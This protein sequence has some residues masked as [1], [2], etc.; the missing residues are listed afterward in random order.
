MSLPA[1]IPNS[2]ILLASGEGWIVWLLIIGGM[3]IFNLVKEDSAKRKYKEELDNIS[4]F[5]IKATKTTLP[6]N[7]NLGSLPCFQIEFK[8]WANHPTD[9]EIKFDLLIKD[10]S[11]DENGEEKLTFFVSPDSSLT[12]GTSRVFRF[13]RIYKT[14]PDGYFDDYITFI[15]VP[16]QYLGHPFK[17]KRTIR[18]YLVGTDVNVQS[19]Y[20]IY[21]DQKN[22]IRHLSFQDISHTFSEV[23][24]MEN[25]LNRDEIEK[26][27]IQVALA[28]A[29]ADGNL[30]QKE[31]NEIKKWANL[32]I[33]GLDEDK[34]KEKKKNLTKFIKESYEIAKAK[35]LS[36][37]TLLEVINDKALK[38][39]KYELIDLLL[40]VVGADDTLSK[41]EDKM[42][43]SIVKKL[44][45]DQNTFN[46]MKNKTLAVIGKI[47]TSASSESGEEL[48][49]LSKDMTDAEKCKELRK[50]FS[51]WNG[52]TNSTNKKIKSRAQEM[53]KLIAELRSK[54]DC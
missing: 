48:L 45:I 1:I 52:Q 50:L 51:K 22:Q 8:G 25:L 47:E 14:S 6:E 9:E 20:G 10:V 13:S 27:S 5:K 17:G 4:P 18:F 12:E 32:A 46:E 29:A 19:E 30:N 2:E 54:Y 7:Y 43:V 21:S 31:L 16:I 34:A 35:K 33:F 49:G 36:L 28:I 3:F 40:K 24:F 53:T 37:S 15:H 44:N 26:A 41:E 11:E 23:G 38:E 42:L 39:Q